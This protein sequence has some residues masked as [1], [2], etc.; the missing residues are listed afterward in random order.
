VLSLALWGEKAEEIEEIEIASAL[1]QVTAL[2]VSFWAA[3][4]AK[5]CSQASS[6]ILG[7]QPVEVLH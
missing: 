3:M 2:D 7:Q 6:W 1:R 4:P 5:K